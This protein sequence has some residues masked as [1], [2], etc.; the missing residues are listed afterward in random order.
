[1]STVCQLLGINP[2]R[3]LAAPGGRPIPI[4]DNQTESPQPIAELLG[5]AKV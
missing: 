1:M 4:V 2:N 5:G 3:E